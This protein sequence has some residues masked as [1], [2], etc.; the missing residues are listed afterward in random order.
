MFNFFRTK[1]YTVL[2]ILGEFMPPSFVP[3]FTK[4]TLVNLLLIFKRQEFPEKV[5]AKA[6]V[7]SK[8]K[9]IS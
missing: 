1:A 3:R 4:K 7:N 9:P 5:D 6:L 8:G 2:K